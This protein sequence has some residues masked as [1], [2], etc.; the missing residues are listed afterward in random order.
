MVRLRALTG[1]ILLSSCLLQIHGQ[2]YAPA[3]DDSL[4]VSY[5]PASSDRIFIFNRPAF[6]A[7]L[8]ISIEAW[9]EDRTTGWNFIWS[10]YDTA[11]DNYKVIPFTHTGPSA[12]IDTITISSGYQVM[13]TKGS[14]NLTFRVWLLFN[15]MKVT[16]TNKDTDQKLSF[17]YYNCSS[18]DLRADTTILPLSYPIPYV[19]SALRVFNYHTI[20]WTADNPQA[21]V[22]SSRLVT[23]VNDPPVT[24]TWYFLNVTDRFGLKRKDSVYYESIISEAKLTA[25]YVSLGDTSA[26]PGKPYGSYYDDDILSAPGIYRF[27]LSSSV[28]AT[29]SLIKFGDGEELQLARGEV[30]AEHQYMHP[31]IYQVKLITKSDAPYECTD[32]ASVTVELAYASFSLPNVFTPNNDGD[33]DFLTLYDDNNV[34]RSEDVSVVAIE[35]TIFDRS[36]T[37][38]HT[39]SGDIR[40]W[41]GWDGKV[42]GTNRM[43]PEGV[44]FYVIT[45]LYGMENKENPIDKDVVKGFFHLY[46]E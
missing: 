19:D 38:M 11:A 21:A 22:P 2:I 17:G 34:F 40:D 41:P 9:P 20:R 1:I 14:Q 18:F 13:M 29:T 30:K 27:D 24:D 12:S 6:G 8:Q 39:Y 44:Y 26:Y 32:S 42:R 23:R 43:A 10:V 15:D 36:G 16:I 46:R 31:G 37:R 25:T 4:M 35:L 33:N 3:A 28:N 5:Q 7:T 45:L